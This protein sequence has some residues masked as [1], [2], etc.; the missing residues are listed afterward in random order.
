M[1]SIADTTREE[2]IPE[3]KPEIRREQSADYKLV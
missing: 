2:N 1:I 3:E